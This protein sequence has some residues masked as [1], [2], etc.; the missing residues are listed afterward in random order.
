MRWRDDKNTFDKIAIRKFRAEYWKC[1]YFQRMRNFEIVWKSREWFRNGK[2]TI[3]TSVIKIKLIKKYPLSSLWAR[4]WFNVSFYINTCEN[5]L[6]MKY[7]G[8]K[9]V[10]YRLWH[11]LKLIKSRSR[12]KRHLQSSFPHI[13]NSK[14]KQQQREQQ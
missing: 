12:R 1:T 4:S 7:I 6:T 5:A 13:E 10:S 14:S 3:Q 2:N 8:K 11:G 9:N